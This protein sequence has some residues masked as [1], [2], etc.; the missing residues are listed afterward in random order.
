MSKSPPPAEKENHERWV[1]SYADLITLLLGFFIILYATSKVDA[2]KFKLFAFGLNQAF[3]V[4]VREGAPGGS[5]VLDGGRGLLPGPINTGTIERDLNLVREAVR[6]RSDAAGLAGQLVVVRQDDQIV[7]RLADSLVFPSASADIRPDALRLLDV[8]ASVVREVPHEVRIEGHTDNIPPATDRYPTNWEL[9]SA[10]STAVLRYLVERGGIDAKRV[11]AA[12]FGEF[13]PL[14]PNDT[15]EGRAL[16]R[17]ADI[18]LLY[19]RGGSSSS[20]Q[21]AVA[22]TRS[23]D[24]H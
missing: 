11:S 20:A 22:P 13:H 21:P 3:N 5:P 16:N 18:V 17:R 10:R 6:D 19:P 12:G 15:P 2:E 14:S 9:A 8:A 23:G 7:I 1:I 4:G 24:G